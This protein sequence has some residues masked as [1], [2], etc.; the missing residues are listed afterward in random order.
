MLWKQ[1]RFNEKSLREE[2]IFWRKS[3]KISLRKASKLSGISNLFLSQFEKGNSIGL[4][5]ALSLC[6]AMTYTP[7][8]HVPLRTSL[9]DKP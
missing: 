3:K 5:S 8:W 1:K 6:N 4:N 2:F 9:V 7:V